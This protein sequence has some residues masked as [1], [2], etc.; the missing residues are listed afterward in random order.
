M[1]LIFLL[2]IQISLHPFTS[3]PGQNLAPLTYNEH[4]FVLKREGGSQ[5]VQNFRTFMEEN[6][7][8][9]GD[10]NLTANSTAQ[11]VKSIRLSFKDKKGLD[12]KL[13]LTG[14]ERF[15]LRW[16]LDEKGKI[17]Y[18]TY[19]VNDKEPKY[20]AIDKSKGNHHVRVKYS[21]TH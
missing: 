20:L 14:F 3:W 21:E 4:Y 6:L 11:E 10:V 1:K 16:Q 9:K 17:S 15:E 2:L 7:P 19:R 12:I 5:A 18:C 13:Q 8:F